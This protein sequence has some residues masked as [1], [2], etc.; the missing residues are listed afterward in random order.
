MNAT[1]LLTDKEHHRLE[2]QAMLDSAK[3]QAERN[4]MGQFATPS[5]LASEILSYAKKLIPHG[6]KVR[7]FDP[8]FGTGAFYSALLQIFS[9][10]RI[11]GATGYEIDP[12]YCDP[13]LHLWAEMP[14]DLRLS[15]FTK[16]PAPKDRFNLLI[17]N[18]PYVR[19]HH[20]INGE[21]TRIRAASYKACGLQFGGLAGLYCHFLG[22]SHAWMEDGGVAGWLIPSEFMDVNYGATLKRYL[23]DKVRLL[24]I[25]RFDPYD[26]QFGDALVS[27]AVVWFRKERPPQDYD[28]EFSFGGTLS[29]PKQSRM[30]SANTLRAA[31]KWTRFPQQDIHHAKSVPTLSDFFEIRRGLATGDNK[32][33]ILT[34]QQIAERGL[35]P[36]FFKP[37]LPS[38]RYLPVAEISSDDRG[39]PLV[40]NPLFLLDCRLPEADV[41]RQYPTLWRYFQEGRERGVATRYL[42]Q[43]RSPWYA[44][45][46]RPPAPFLCTYLGRGNV[47]T[48]RPFRFILN[49]SRATVTN[50]YLALYPKRTV[51][52]AIKQDPSCA[53]RVWEILSRIS[54]A[55]M[56][57]EGRVYGGGLHKL[58]PKELANVPAL[59]LADFLPEPSRGSRNGELFS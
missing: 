44:Q 6:E 11:A 50:V 12:H 38:P 14:L 2:I 46:N 30:I 57:A 56:L 54:P 55:S 27:S 29:D 24:H 40:Q 52:R 36:D 18:P 22:L 28:V 47:K 49:Q 13:T 25:H 7:F 20:I 45:E 16:A 5:L 26:V 48:G 32:Y 39:N 8:A 10:N 31:P 1:A 59:D 43:H 3:T 41:E 51:T 9:L 17:C 37:I 21:K 42:C 33:F 58:E 53:R 19:H 4:R 15:D 23:L 34:A 35:P